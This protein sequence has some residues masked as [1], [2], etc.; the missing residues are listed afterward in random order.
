MTDIIFHHHPGD[1]LTLSN[2][3]KIELIIGNF[4]LIVE[5]IKLID[6]NNFLITVQTPSNKLQRESIIRILN[7]MLVKGEIIDYSLSS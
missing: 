3:S 6:I 2:N 7:K 5:K 1:I 4:K